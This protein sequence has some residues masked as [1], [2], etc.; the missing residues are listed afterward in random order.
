MRS[1]TPGSFCAGADLIERRTMTNEQVT[2]FLSDLRTAFS[3]LEDL[4]VPTI[5][6]IDG[7]ALG[8]GL[9][10]ALACDFRI[11]GTFCASRI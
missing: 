4:P 10:L 7:P 11:A 8:G 9:E 5:A 2:Q 6:A 1:T 3:S